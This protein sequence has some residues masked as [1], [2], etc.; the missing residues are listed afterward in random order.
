M[1]RFM[2]TAPP[3]QKAQEAMEALANQL[4]LNRAV[5]QIL[6]ARGIDTAEKAK[7][8][9][10]GIPLHDPFALDRMDLAAAKIHQQIES[11]NPILL[12]G[13][14]DCDGVCACAILAHVLEGID[15]KST[16]L[17]SSHT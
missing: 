3:D 14:Y 7:G 10:Y 8:F 11:D 16:R 2:G 13:D 9:L 4:G 17:N 6:Y 15:R 5:A 1:I 12:Y